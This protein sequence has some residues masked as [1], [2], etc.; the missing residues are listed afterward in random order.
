[1]ETVSEIKQLWKY[2]EIQD[3]ESL[4]VRVHNSGTDLD[5]FVVTQSTSNG[6][7]SCVINDIEE[8]GNCHFYLVQQRDSRGNFVIPSV[9]QMILDKNLDY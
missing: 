1:M 7:Q 3:D 2:L 8:L 4:V 9:Q 5:E 6:L